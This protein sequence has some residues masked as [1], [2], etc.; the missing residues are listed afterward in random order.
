MYGEP[1]Q[2]AA[3]LAVVD[4]G[5]FEAAA[6]ELR[7]SPSAISQRI[8]ALEHRL[9]QVV[10]QRARPVRAT[11]VGEVL[12]RHARQLALLE[13]ETGAALDPSA[14]AVPLA[15][16]INADSLATW[17]RPLLPWAAGSG[18]I[19]L[20]L[21]VEDQAHST[22][23]LRAGTVLGAVTDDP[24]PVQGCAVDELASMTYVPVAV[25]ALWERHGRRL[26]G[27][28]MVVFNDKDNLQHQVLRA[29]GLDEPAVVHRVPSSE[30]F[31]E[32]VRVGLGWGALPL[33]QLGDALTAGD[34][35]EV[36]PGHDVTVRLWWQRWR[37]GSPALD[38][39]TA[40]LREESRR[41][42]ARP[43]PPR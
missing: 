16:A 4:E 41:R 24:T 39:L 22:A 14:G 17:A 28:P 8:K 36:A 26:E 13:S 21:H 29:L 7:V 18:D 12:V 31:A 40:W 35:V 6:D 33:E 3:L 38:R 32:A 25:R 30:A 1:H 9:G 19:A 43:G 20:R 5:S 11:P 23:L 2:L 10:V 15:V 34:L 42:A 27:L 37:L